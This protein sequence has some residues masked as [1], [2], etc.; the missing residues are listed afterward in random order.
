MMKLKLGLFLFDLPF[1]FDVSESKASSLFTTWVELMA[2]ELD[3]VISWPDRGIIQR[4]LPSMFRKYYPKYC[5]IGILTVLN[6]LLRLHPVLKL[7]QWAGPTTSST[8]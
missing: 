8:T 1:R 7:Q 3:W 2:K 4:N 5:V 6:C